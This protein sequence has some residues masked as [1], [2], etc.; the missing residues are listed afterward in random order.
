[1]NHKDTFQI[2]TYPLL[3]PVMASEM[4]AQVGL[5]EKRPGISLTVIQG[6]AEGE[7]LTLSFRTNS[8]LS[9][10]TNVPTM[11]FLSLSLK[12]LRR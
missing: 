4:A 7:M 12:R 5:D 8:P 6:A 3:Y 1:M 10:R 9:F 11:S 2:K